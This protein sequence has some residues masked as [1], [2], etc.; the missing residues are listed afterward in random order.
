METFKPS[1]RFDSNEQPREKLL[2]LIKNKLDSELVKREN[3]YTHGSV[4]VRVQGERTL[5]QKINFS[6]KAELD[7]QLEQFLSDLPETSDD[8]ILED[9]SLSLSNDE[10]EEI[11][12]N[13]YVGL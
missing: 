11:S 13:N 6:N 10:G 8:Y 12:Y 4:V 9:V 7:Q 3:N 1:E 2:P 5:S